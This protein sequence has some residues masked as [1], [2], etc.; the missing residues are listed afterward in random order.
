MVILRHI[1]W[2]NW[3][4]PCPCSQC[5]KAFSH[6]FVLKWHQRIHTGEK[7]YNCNQCVKAVFKNIGSLTSIC[8]HILKRNHINTASAL[9]PFCQKIILNHIWW[10]KL[11]R[12]HINAISVMQLSWSNLSL[13]CILGGTAYDNSFAFSLHIMSVSRIY[14]PN[15]IKLMLCKV[16]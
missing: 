15:V 16:L 5:D 12:N 3:E 9:K 7:A 13:Y 14:A 4:K 10:Y 1:W 6:N 2:H 11:G 8:W